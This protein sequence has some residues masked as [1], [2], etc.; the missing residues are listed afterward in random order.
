MCVH[1]SSPC[2]WETELNDQK[3]RSRGT[4][5]NCI[6]TFEF[7]HDVHSLPSQT[8]AFKLHSSAAINMKKNFQQR[9]F[10]LLNTLSTVSS[11]CPYV[12][13]NILE[14]DCNY[15][16]CTHRRRTWDSCQIEAHPWCPCLEMQS[17]GNS[18]LMT[19]GVYTNSAEGGMVASALATPRH[20]GATRLYLLSCTELPLSWLFH[21]Q[22]WV[23]GI[24]LVA[25]ALPRQQVIISMAGLVLAWREACLLHFTQD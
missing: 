12:C 11:T 25:A 4:L 18:Q 7:M 6:L 24:F 3:S 13:I 8:F 2:L 16:V 21:K 23:E 5:F 20:S 22:G 19:L 14:V 10:T 1:Q 17:L 15:S 9:N